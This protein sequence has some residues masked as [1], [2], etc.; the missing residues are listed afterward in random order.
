MAIIPPQEA[1]TSTYGA[2]SWAAASTAVRSV[3]PARAVVGWETGVEGDGAPLMSVVPGRSKAQTLVNRATWGNT[4]VSLGWG[5]ATG[6]LVSATWVQSS[7][8]PWAPDTNTTVGEPLP[9]HCR[10]IWR[11]PPMSTR[12]A[13][14]V[15]A[16]G[17]A[18]PEAVVSLVVGVR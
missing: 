14:E 4:A 6:L 9:W 15:T 1:P 16:L 2:G 17:P 11:P 8:A 12:P 18:F 5:V 10:Y 7:W 3:T 13:K